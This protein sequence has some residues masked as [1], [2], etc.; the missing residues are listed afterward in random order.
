MFSTKE[1]IK[2]NAKSPSSILII[3]HYQ[4]LISKVSHFL[5]F[6]ITTEYPNPLGFKLKSLLEMVVN[7]NIQDLLKIPDAELYGEK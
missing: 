7:L 5:T 1:N 2:T 3:I 4:Y 6:D